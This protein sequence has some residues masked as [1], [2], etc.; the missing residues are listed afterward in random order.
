MDFKD[1]SDWERLDRALSEALDLPAAQRGSWLAQQLGEDTKLFDQAMRLLEI[2]RESETRFDMFQASRNAVLADA[3]IEMEEPLGD[4]RIG[5]KYGAWQIV[6]RI[7]SGGHSVVYEARRD[8]GRYNQNA[9]LK[10]MHGGV[11]NGDAVRHFLRERQILSALD[12]PGIVRILDAGET[13]TGAPWMAMDLAPGKT[14]TEYCQDT[15]PPLNERLRLVADIADALQSAHSRLI[16]HRDIKPDNIIVSNDGRIR[17][18]D[19]GIASLLS[20]D[21]TTSPISAM[22]PAY[23]SPEQLAFDPVTTASDI[24]QLGR[25]LADVCAGVDIPPELQAVINKATNETASERYNSAAGLASDLK[26][27]VNGQAPAARPDTGLQAAVRFAKHNKVS[28][29]LASVLVFGSIS[30]AV[31]VTAHAHALD[32]QR[33][34][35][36]AAADR[37]DRGRSVLLDTFRRLDPL[38]QDGMAST[39]GDVASLLEP[40]L[41]D[42]RSRLS[43]DPLLAAELVGWVART[44]DRSGDIEEAG[45]LAQDAVDLLSAAKMNTST[46]YALALAYAGSLKGKAGD[47]EAEVAAVEKALS[48]A[49][50]APLTDLPALD[51]LLIAAWSHEG[52]WLQ[53][54]ALFTEALPRIS[55]TG[56][57]PSEIEARAGLSRALIG[58]GKSEE[59]EE[60][61]R[62]A[63]ELTEIYYGPQHPRL[64]LPLSDLGRILTA[65]GKYEEAART[66]QRAL[67]ISTSAFG[68]DAP[69][70]V[71][72]RNNLTITLMESGRHQEAI[73]QYALLLETIARTNGAD[74]LAFGEALQNMAVA[75]TQAGLYQAALVSL[76][77]AERIFVSRLPEG[78]PRRAFPSLTRSEI[79]I[80]QK[81]YSDAEKEAQ[82]AFS[83]LSA[84]LPPRHYAIEIAKCRIGLAKFGK[85]EL[86]SARPFIS[87]SVE[88]LRSM[89]D[90]P[91]RL[92]TPCYEV[93]AAL[94]SAPSP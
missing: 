6:R 87:T 92:V 91:A 63:V 71:S 67:E 8:D 61:S 89:G 55:A 83:L 56:S 11:L 34:L 13:A 26:R 78:H 75:Q 88:S 41:E 76:A 43:D 36:V 50:T 1:S 48:I 39:D 70:T 74:S 60:Q 77:G 90:L 73:D 27:I 7:G 69:S 66:Q 30:V 93:A 17:L 84:S 35:A 31:I 21:E 15:I 4:P 86:S 5:A 65:R 32:H 22:T 18:L 51:T 38:E 81:R 33:A 59:A 28:A 68:V 45:R 79:L 85:G 49:Q 57:I 46:E 25:V 12:H 29:A 3:A 16:I 23:A 42:V 72:H 19:F 52:D 80:S 9:A 14:I 10:V 94:E 54:H 62:H 44:K 47:R 20:G 64:A 2:E 53:Q 58:L 37:A 82:R 24:Y 40:T